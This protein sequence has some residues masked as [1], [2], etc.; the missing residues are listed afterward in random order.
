VVTEGAQK[1]G[2]MVAY[3]EV[4]TK[5]VLSKTRWHFAKVS[6][7]GHMVRATLWVASGMVQMEMSDSVGWPIRF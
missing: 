4:R 5:S 2:L 7:D 3:W 6:H 1:V